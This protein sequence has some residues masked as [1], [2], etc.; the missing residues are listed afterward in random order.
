MRALPVVPRNE[1]AAIGGRLRSV[2]QLRQM[3]IEQLASATGLSKSFLSR[4]ER[5]QT[6]PSVSTLVLLC[7][8]LNIEVGELFSAPDAQ[9]VRFDDAPQI[10]LGGTNV[11]ERLLSPRN[12][13][14]FQVVR[15]RVDAGM[16]G[17]GGEELYSVNC[18]VDFLHVLRGSITVVLAS[19]TWDLE[20]GD[21]ITLDGREPHTWHTRDST[22]GVELLWVLAPA[23]W[24][25]T[26]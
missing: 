22:E 15:S 26:T 18:E 6:S 8:V 23:A 2:R 16:S 11:Y 20:S 4:V 14:R 24:G 3:T 13:P 9:L 10:N 19:E 12:D 1:P 21:S 25:G 5:D 7:D 17:T